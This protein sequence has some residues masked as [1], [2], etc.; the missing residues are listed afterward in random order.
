[1]IVSIKISLFLPT[2]I[3]NQTELLKLNGNKLTALPGEA[4]SSLGL[5]NLINLRLRFNN[6]VTVHKNAFK[7]LKK[8]QVLVLDYNQIPSLDAETF[9]DNKELEIISLSNNPIKRL[10]DGLFTN[11]SQLANVEV[12]NCELSYIG[13]KTFENVPNLYYLYLNGNKLVQVDFSV[14]LP[15]KNLRMI[16]DKN[17]WKC[18][19]K[20]RS[21]RDWMVK[22]ALDSSIELFK[23]RSPSCAQPPQLANKTWLDTKSEDFVC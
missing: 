21:L 23:D 19:C 9:R 3:N 13:P 18:D 17:P 4:F 5:L 22:G 15:L 1:L 16:L 12:E 11:M 6:I 7:N 10:E 14:L 8:L 20:L 2:G